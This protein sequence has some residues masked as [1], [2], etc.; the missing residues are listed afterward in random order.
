MDISIKK[1]GWCFIILFISLVSCTP[2]PSDYDLVKKLLVQTY[3][4]SSV[5]FKSYT[6]YSFMLDTV[7]YANSGCSCW[8]LVFNGGGTYVTDITD[9]VKSALDKA[10]YKQVDSV[11]APDLAM[12]VTVVEGYKVS[13]GHNY[14]FTQYSYGYDLYTFPFV[15]TDYLSQSTLVIEL[16]DVK[17]KKN[18][19]YKS[20][21]VAYLSDVGSTN[22]IKTNP[23]LIAGIQQA[24]SQSP[25]LTGN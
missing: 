23:T 20:I 8:A 15:E 25:Y 14:S 19:V 16:T 9:N 18:G 12:H 10:G 5:N 24:F 4:D 6:T 7:A 22:D 13:R 21:W 2:K 17:N 11:S 1:C 3:Y